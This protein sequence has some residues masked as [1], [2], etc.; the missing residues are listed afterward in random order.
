MSSGHDPRSVM[1]AIENLAAKRH[2][3][4]Q[5]SLKAKEEL[6]HQKRSNDESRQVEVD[7]RWDKKLAIIEEFNESVA[8]MMSIFQNSRFDE[9]ALVASNPARVLLINLM[10]GILRGLGFAVGFLLM[11]LVALIAIKQALPADGLV[12]LIRLIHSA[13]G[14]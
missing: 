1:S 13:T 14:Q 5:E 8:L 6:D 9:L 7:K 11:V 2:V 3:I 4:S 12:T 10:I